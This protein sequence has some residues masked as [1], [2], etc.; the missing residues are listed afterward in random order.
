MPDRF[1]GGETQV[2]PI[3]AVAMLVAIVL[4]MCLP[5]RKVII[6]FLAA[7]LLI[8]MDQMVLIGPFHFQMLRILILFG[9]IRIFMGKPARDPVFSNGFNGIDAAVS[10]WA[11]STAV[12]VVMLWQDT[13]SLN[14]QLGVLYTVFGIYFFLRAFVRDEKDIRQALT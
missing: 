3:I 9:C 1:G 2:H 7:G 11:I 13:A 14:N 6:P 8:P 4:I 10:L 5:R 12:C